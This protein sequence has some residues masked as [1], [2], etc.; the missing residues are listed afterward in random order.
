MLIKQTLK[1][2]FK[3][4][5]SQAEYEAFIIDMVI[6]LEMGASRLKANIN[7]QLVANQVAGKYQAREPQLIKYL[8]NV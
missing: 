5:N 8:H 4:S 6:S 1:C 3:Y 2:E 7:S